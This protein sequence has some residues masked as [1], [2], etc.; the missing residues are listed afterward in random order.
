MYF[1]FN[2]LLLNFFLIHSSFT[3]PI[4]TVPGCKEVCS[5]LSTFKEPTFTMSIWTIICQD[6][7]CVIKSRGYSRHEIPRN[8]S[9]KETPKVFFDLK[10]LKLTG[11]N[12]NE[13]SLDIGLWVGMEWE[14][15]N[16]SM[17]NCRNEEGDRTA[18][19]EGGG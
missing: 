16:L 14:D 2:F 10:L 13:D 5:H 15:M 9:D 19:L 18:V 12:F 6:M 4:I 17:C 8:M 1:L 11:V 7:V 3:S